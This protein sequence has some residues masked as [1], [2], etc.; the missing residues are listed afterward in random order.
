[1]LL[2]AP[3]VSVQI[4]DH[5]GPVVFVFRCVAKEFLAGLETEAC[6]YELRDR[7]SGGS[8]PVLLDGACP[9][10]ES[11]VRVDDPVCIHPDS[12]HLPV[13]TLDYHSER[14]PDL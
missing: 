1:M 12:H 3:G 7:N 6:G 14:G 9:S 8:F 13:I 10:E 4:C 11:E 5:D 2:F